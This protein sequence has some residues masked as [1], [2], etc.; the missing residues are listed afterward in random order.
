MIAVSEA[1]TPRTRS[2]LIGFS[3][4][5]LLLLAMLALAW[6]RW[7]GAIEQWFAPPPTDD[8]AQRIAVLEAQLQSQSNELRQ[9]SER[10]VGN[11]SAQRII[12]DDLLGIGERAAL[13]EEAVN[14]LADPEI[15]SSQSLRLDEA[16]LLLVM[17]IERLEL[18]NDRAAAE[19]A[20]VLVET[21]FSALS[22]PRWVSLRQTLAQE[23]AALRAA[24]EDPRTLALAT[25]DTLESA[26]DAL[27]SAPHRDAPAPLLPRWQ[28]LLGQLV[29]VR[30]SDAQ[31]V[32]ASDEIDQARTVLTLELALARAALE[33]RD[34]IGFRGALTR[35]VATLQRLYPES[36]AR[37]QQI[38]ELQALHALQLRL[39]LPVLGSTL[40]QLRAV[41]NDTVSGGSR[42]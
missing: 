38:S 39:D 41:R 7:H 29:Q 24:P 22:N 25:L 32:L 21:I 28:A 8:T 31:H 20:Y 40:E 34:E 27:A 10:I 36:A 2:R 33:R 35:I 6:W 18:A 5:S 26:L 13:L 15:A 12:R 19:R 9:L 37:Q 11:A 42:P 17:A 4:A 1:P 30:R 23:L 16:E 3:V 14:R